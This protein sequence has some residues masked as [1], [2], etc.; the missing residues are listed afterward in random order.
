MKQ[1][2]KWMVLLASVLA[3]LGCSWTVAAQQPT[4][5]DTAGGMPIITE[6]GGAD[7]AVVFCRENKDLTPAH[8]PWVDSEQG[9]AVRFNGE[10]A[11]FR[12]PAERLQLEDFTLSMWV[13]WDGPMDD[14]GVAAALNQRMFAAVGE[15]R[16][17]QYITLS[18]MDTLPNGA[19]VLRY[20]MNHPQA[21]V[22]LTHPKNRSLVAKKWQ[23]VVVVSRDDTIT[24]YLNE[25]LL[26]DEPSSIRTADLQLK[27]LYFGKGV[28]AEGDG[29]F[30]G[31]M[32]NVYL[33]NRA[34]TIEE[35]RAINRA[36]NP[37]SATSTTTTAPKTEP[38]VPEVPLTADT[39]LPP[40]PPVVWMVSGAVLALVAVLTVIANVRES[41]SSSK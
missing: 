22:E 1:W 9:Q 23:H 5:F 24:L 33:Y 25:V 29:Y 2:C 11:Y 3:M 20:Y 7:A 16:G 18:P 13:N 21:Y 28:T 39:T 38:L 27:Q 14:N 41:K 15:S 30:S 4:G 12:L 31:L 34:L 8:I 37:T 6:P 17:T 40:I 32:D 26:A 19:G 36:Q 10:D 35:I